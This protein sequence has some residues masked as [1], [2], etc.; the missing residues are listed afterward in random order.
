MTQIDNAQSQ[1][2]ATT[3]VPGTPAGDPNASQLPSAPAAEIDLASLERVW[4]PD[5]P[6]RWHAVYMIIERIAARAAAKASQPQQETAS[7]DDTAHS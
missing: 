7:A 6:S 1:A 4:F 2:S 3:L 5:L